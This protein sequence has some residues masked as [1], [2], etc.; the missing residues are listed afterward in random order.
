MKKALEEMLTLESEFE[1]YY[2]EREF[3]IIGYKRMVLNARCIYYQNKHMILLAIDDIT[4][5]KAASME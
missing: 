1:D 4:D 2:V 5:H 3:P